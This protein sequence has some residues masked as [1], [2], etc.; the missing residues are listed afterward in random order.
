MSG[1]YSELAQRKRRAKATRHCLRIIL[2]SVQRETAL[3]TLAADALKPRPIASTPP[4]AQ[5]M[6]GFRALFTNFAGKEQGG[7]SA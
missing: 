4:A 3:A 5:N 1:L 2:S 6:E 7:D